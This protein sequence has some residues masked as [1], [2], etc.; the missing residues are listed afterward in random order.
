MNT[1]HRIEEI[2]RELQ[3]LSQRR[4]EL[5]AELKTLQGTQSAEKIYGLPLENADPSSPEGKVAIF[6]SLFR[7]REDVYPRYWEN[8][9]S[10]KK[11]FSPVCSNE[12]I[13]GICQ[14]PKMKCSECRHQAFTPFSEMI[15]KNHLQGREVIGTYAIQPNNQC[16]FLAADFDKSTWREDALAYQKSARSIGAEV[17]IE[18][19]RS[20]N[21]AHAWIFFA[22]EIQAYQARQ[23]G[24]LILSLASLQ[25]PTLSLSSYDRFFPNQDVIPKGGFGNLIALPLQRQAR[26]QGNSV[27][28]NSDMQPISHQW[29]YLASVRR[30]TPEDLDLILA[31]HFP[32]SKLIESE[33]EEVDRSTAEALMDI[34]VKKTKEEEFDGIIDIEQSD[35][36]SID[37]RNLPSKVF[38]ALKRSATLANP[39]FF[40]LQNMRRSTWKTPR[41]I[42]CGEMKNDRLILPRGNLDFCKELAEEIG[43]EVVLHDM[44]PK[45]KR[46][47]FKFLGEL[48]P[49]QNRAVKKMAQHDYGV[50][51]APPGVGKTVMGCSMIAK[52]KVS[53]LVL[54]H[55]KPL[56]DQWID[57]I[58]KLIDLDPKEIGSYGGTKKKPKGKIDVAMLQTLGNL[59]DSTEFLSQYGQII[60]DECH[61][62][63]A[64]SFE[65]VLKKIPARYFLGLTATPVRKD[66]LQAILHMQCGPIRHE[67]EEYG[68]KDLLKRVLVKETPFQLEGGMLSGQLSIHQIWD[69][70]I[71]CPARL[72]MVAQDVKLSVDEGGYP[73]V[74]S[75]RKEHLVLLA[76]IISKK[77]GENANGLL[78]VGDMGKKERKKV[79]ET[80]ENCTQ[81]KRAFYLL[82]TSSLVGEGVDLPMLDR[83][84]LA[85]PVSWKGRL[86][87]YAGRIHR[88][89]PGKK[90]V[91]IYDYLDPQIGLTVSMFKKRITTYKKMGYQIES[92]VG[93]KAENLIY[94]RDL[95]SEFK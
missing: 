58:K 61:H 64:T 7:C 27:F 93:S 82:A 24:S 89:H 52:R 71:R 84:I 28:L 20:G 47:R 56:M 17:A 78:L 74:V 72:E 26:S 15:A 81:K 41:Y 62:I 76:Q 46:K 43:A 86:K 13:P 2:E 83:L 90:E 77:I 40:K 60:I 57:Q 37:A 42:F 9:K 12:W 53:T 44:R 55:K 33:V 75:D 50:L 67:M 18:R 1:N 45:F 49:D 25:R 87:Q 70:L 51:V 73:L 92:P 66:G 91:R 29:Q 48:R 6:L 68:A 36:L 23:L 8:Q 69:Q 79:F 65:G 95:F 22:R 10:G 39:E 80:I 5:L 19:S 85:M 21:G 16:R 38:S 3:S 14:K 32:V 88:P 31:R 34:V 35:Q 30:L 63:P 59:E 11:G 4:K 94:Q 54:V